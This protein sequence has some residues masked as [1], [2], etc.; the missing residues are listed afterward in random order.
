MIMNLVIC[1]ECNHKIKL[2]EHPHPN[3][4]LICSQCKLK[5]IVANIKP[6]VIDLVQSENK[7]KPKIVA[8][9]ATCPACDDLIRFRNNPHRGQR[10]SC[11]AC[12]TEIEIISVKPLELDFAIPETDH[13]KWNRQHRLESR[14]QIRVDRHHRRLRKNDNS[15]FADKG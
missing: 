1:P 14:S 7:P 5:L 13:R 3:Q 9:E 4:R 15:K 8:I 2:S 12:Q 10:M 11:L 6:L